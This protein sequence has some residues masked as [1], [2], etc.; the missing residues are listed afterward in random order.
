MALPDTL[1]A[2]NILSELGYTQPTAIGIGNDNQSTIKIC[3]NY[4]N[5]GNTRHL[6]LRFSIVRD[7]IERNI[8]RMFYLPT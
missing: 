2:E 4:S 7:N 5:K 6:S 1:Y 3:N 8:I